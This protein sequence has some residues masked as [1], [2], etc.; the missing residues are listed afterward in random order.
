MFDNVVWYVM[1]FALAD[2]VPLAGA[3]EGGGATAMKPSTADDESAV[4]GVS[5]GT[6]GLRTIGG[7]RFFAPGAASLFAGA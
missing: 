4:A 2:G 5:V 3:D 1:R 7:G 6:L